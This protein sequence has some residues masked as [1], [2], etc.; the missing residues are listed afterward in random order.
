[1]MSALRF[2]KIG[3]KNKKRIFN[4]N[5]FPDWVKDIL[6][7]FKEYL[8]LIEKEVFKLYICHINVSNL[9]IEFR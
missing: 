6:R 8:G 9:A 7:F 5:N 4:Y 1:M 3:D 2:F